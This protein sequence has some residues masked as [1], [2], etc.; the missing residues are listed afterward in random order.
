[1][2]IMGRISFSCLFPASWHFS[3]S[4][5]VLPRLL[6]PSI[7]QLLFISLVVCLIG[8]LYLLLVAG[9]GHVS[10]ITKENHFHRHLAR[11]T[12]IDATDTTNP[13]LNYGLVV[14]CGSS[15]S[16]VFVY[17]WPRHNGNPHELLDI[18]QM[19]DQNRKPVVMKIK[20]GISELAKTP[21]KASDYIY[22]LLSFAAQHIPKHKHQETPLY[23][24]CTAG[25]RI[26]PENQ[27][28]ALLEDL[29]TDIP[30]H[31][32]FLFSD[33]HVEVISGKQEGVYA[34]IG[35]NFV[36]GRF[37][38]VHNDGEAVVEVHVPGGDQQEMLLRKRT[39]GVLDMGGVS[40]QIAYE[41]PKTVSFA[42]PQ[43]EEI[44]KN[45][46][47][48]FNLG[49]DV[50]RTEHVYRVY[51]S[52]FLGYG[53]NA[54]RQRYEENLIRNTAARNRLLDQ[55]I[56][57]TVES[58]LLDPCLPTD[59]Q[60]EIGPP[61]QHLYL[62]GTGDF[63]QC[64]QIL[65]PF[66]NH[67]ND[68]QTSLNGVY[69]PAIDYSN[70]QFYGFSEFYYCMEDVLRMGGDYNASKYAKAAKSYCATQWK[71]LR[72]RFES[73]LYASHADLH[74]LKYQCFKSAWMYEV[75]HTG[76]SFPT[77]YKNLKTAL[78]VY[79][80]EVQWTLGAILYRTRF[81]PLR[82]IQQESLKGAHSHWR[83][84]FSFVNN[85]YLFLACFFIVL[86]SII[87]Y[88]RRLRRI[89][90]RTAQRCTPSSVPWLEEGLG[91]PTI[92]INL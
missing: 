36:L 80:K 45:L 67:T 1:M 38:H 34:W 86:L 12:D 49:C 68:T 64:R 29:R 77:N 22:P 18:R 61:T 3:L 53:G 21:E 10:W 2:S 39:T 6:I 91:S 58:P 52:T 56:G 71:I 75:L 5:Q 51:V 43:Q 74:R 85:H 82:D 27:Q 59:L 55:H 79:D 19:R 66:L 41:V 17:C 76:F 44:A 13:N 23:V 78:L 9:K 42:S 81:L 28:E 30:V 50:H 47:A 83:H 25:M 16:R 70:S 65:Q 89:H 87:L 33:S 62:R 40:T 20:P 24:L 92:L 7:R 54:A 8:L 69:Q 46:L 72:E 4:S 48:E 35:I 73:G 63:D 32:N 90:R 57:E 60:D 88:L 84:S 37:D 14:D 26:L 31:F 15:G 11:V